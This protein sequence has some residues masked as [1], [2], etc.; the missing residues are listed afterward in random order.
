MLIYK[1]IKDWYIMAYFLKQVKQKS[2]R[3]FLEIVDSVYVKRKKSSKH[4]VFKKIGYLDELEKVFI[5]PIAHFKKEASDLEQKRKETSSSQ[6]PLSSSVKNLGSFIF[7]HLL[8]KLALSNAFKPIDYFSKRDYKPY[9]VFEFLT[10]C[11]IIDPASRL[12]S[13]SSHLNSFFVN[14]NFSKNQMYD[15]LSLIGQNDQ[16]I[17]E[18][19]NIRINK[20]YTRNID[21]VFFDCTNFYFEIDA[22]N[23]DDYR[24]PGPS[25]ENRNGAIISLGLLLDFDAIP[26]Y[27]KLFPGNQSEKPII[28][29]V[30]SAM[31][32]SCDVKGKTIRV[33]D[34]GLNCT[35]NIINAHLSGDGY[36]Y[37]K[38]IRSSDDKAMILNPLGYEEIF[39]DD[40][41]V[42]F[43]SKTWI[44]TFEYTF[45]NK[46]Y[47][48]K[49]K[50]MVI[51]SRKYAQKAAYERN[52]AIEK[53]EKT[54]SSS[55]LKQATVSKAV[56]TL[57]DV[58]NNDDGCLIN[59]Q[60]I[61]L[62]LNSSK[63]SK[64]EELDGYYMIITSETN[65]GWKDVLDTYRKLWEIEASFRLTKAQFG[66]RPI[67]ASKLDSIKGHFLTCYV[68]LTLTRLLQKK[69]LNN[70]FN[71]E[72][73][74]KFA[75]NLIAFPIDE[76]TYSLSGYSPLVPAL[77]NRYKISFN[78][79]NLSISKIN[80]LFNF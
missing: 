6:I 56:D 35:E 55:L 13:Y 8:N 41:N 38:A 25:K 74:I 72:S 52:K 29:E 45:N 12:D 64:Q 14:Y 2:G 34:K 57:Y 66:G 65:L 36:I 46:T 47:K 50:R 58:I 19:L 26:L 39:D 20:L 77:E 49:E 17:L 5:D 24:K 73:I 53:V 60:D 30:I 31:K 4:I 16:A 67:Y 71:A 78:Q 21:K 51:W 48:L 63:L 61:S 37:S 80:K 44:D 59:S 69:E 15:A 75:R 40:G 62:I 43:K 3:V 11:R 54:S 70:E 18:Y 7:Y 79:K 23:Y 10:L 42:T 32:N 22:D 1:Y 76:E 9:D 27:Y 28:N 68:A 33:A